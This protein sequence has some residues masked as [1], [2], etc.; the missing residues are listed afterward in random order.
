[1]AVVV[2]LVAWGILHAAYRTKAYETRRAFAI[3][4]ALIGLGV[5]GTFPTFFQAFA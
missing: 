3:A 1:M 5:I 2:W 4:A